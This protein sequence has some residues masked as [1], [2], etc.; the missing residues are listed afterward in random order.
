MKDN[1]IPARIFMGSVTNLSNRPFRRLVTELGADAT[2]SEMVIAF[3]AARGGRQ[4]LALMKRGEHEKTFGVQLV[5][6]SVKQLV[7][8]AEY[9]Q[10]AGAD[11]IDFNCACPHHSVVSH[12]GGA[13]LLR[14][15]PIIAPIL[16]ALRE[17]VKVPLTLKI[18]K[19]F[20]ENDNVV[21]EVVH[22]AEECGVDAVFIHART[23]FAQ[24]RGPNDWAL[25]EEMAQ[26]SKLPIIGCGDLAHGS[27]VLEK[28]QTSACAGF[29]LARGALMKPWIF[30]EIREGHPLDPS[31]EERL[32]ILRKLV[33]YSLDD[34]GYDAF[35]HQKA[36]KFLHDQM[37]F[38]A[39][40]VPTGAY[41]REL[42]MQE[43]ELEWTPRNE[44]EK[45]M[46]QTDK[47]SFDKLLNMVG[48][49]DNIVETPKEVVSETSEAAPEA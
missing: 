43:R 35:G 19:G 38:L 20:E 40:Y 3:Y 41:G 8:S 5:G 21:P 32:E 14:R 24:Y 48:F 11:F 13:D 47:E 49:D 45:L 23:K 28:M 7:K 27:I 2:L 39:R 29:A 25:I 42:P 12:R 34:F 22:I 4:D 1:F 37:L 36:R 9:A 18:R 15:P 30:K 10:K 16:E 6:S 46:A 33:T 17:A 44:L 31:S 26:T